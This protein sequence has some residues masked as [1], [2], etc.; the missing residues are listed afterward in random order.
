MSRP[1]ACCHNRT[2]VRGPH[3][4]DFRASSKMHSKLTSAVTATAP[5]DFLLMSKTAVAAL[6]ALIGIAACGGNSPASAPQGPTAA[7]VAVQPADL[8]SGLGKCDPSG[9]INTYISGDESRHP[10]T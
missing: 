5:N 9:D 1:N 8:S 7:S 6:A 10:T 2:R 3:V 4:N